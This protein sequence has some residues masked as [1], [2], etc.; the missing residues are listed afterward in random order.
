MEGVEFGVGG[1]G[2]GEDALG[3]LLVGRRQG[4]GEGGDEFGGALVVEADAPGGRAEAVLVGVDAPQPVVVAFGQV[5]E[6]DLAVGGGD[7]GV[8]EVVVGEVPAEREEGFK[9]RVAGVGTA[10]EVAG[11]AGVRNSWAVSWRVESQDVRR[12]AFSGPC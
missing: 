10:G 6:A 8:A 2:A 12:S 11:E 4:R 7:V 1:I 3:P 9:G 5:A